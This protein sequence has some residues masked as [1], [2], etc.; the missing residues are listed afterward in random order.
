[1]KK[2]LKYIAFVLMGFLAG[3]SQQ[4]FPGCCSQDL[5]DPTREVPFLETFLFNFKTGS[6]PITTANPDG[7]LNVISQAV[8]LTLLSAAQEE[9][10]QG[11]GVISGTAISNGVPVKDVA[12]KITDVNGTL[13]AIRAEG[14]VIGSHLVL[15]DGSNCP[16][17]DAAVTVIENVCIKGDLFYNGLGGVPDFSNNR[18]T[19]KAG[20]FTVFNLPPGDV[21]LWTFRGGRGNARI[22]V[23]EDKISVG[24]VQVVPIPISTVLVEGVATEAKNESTLIAGA[25][26][27]ILGTQDSDLK[28]ITNSIGQY[29]LNPVG[30]N[31]KHL[32]KAEMSGHWTTYLTLN[33]VSIQTNI[34]VPG[35]TRNVVLYEN[36]YVNE[37][38]APMGS[39]VNTNLGIVTGLVQFGT[40][41][42]QHCAKFTVSDAAGI[43]LLSSGAV[44]VYRPPKPGS[45]GVDTLRAA[46]KN[47]SDPAQTG[48]DGFYFIYNLPP[49]EIFLNYRA[50]VSTG[51]PGN[52]DVSTG[53]VITTAF[54]G[55]VFVQALFNSGSGVSQ[56]LS[57]LIT[58]EAVVPA[59]N[60]QITVLG[61]V[62]RTYTICINDCNPDPSD[63]SPPP[64]DLLDVLLS[65]RAESDASGTYTIEKSANNND[66]DYPLVGGTAY[67]L[68]TSKVGVP[69]TYQDVRMTKTATKLDLLSALSVVPGA[70]QGKIYGNLINSATGRLA[71]DVRLIIT[72]LSGNLLQEITSSDGVFQTVDLPPGLVNLAIVSG[73]DSGNTV[74]RVYANG[75]TFV[76]WVMSKTI[77]AEVSA[78]GG[79]RDLDNTLV[80][81]ATLSVQGRLPGQADSLIVDGSG[82]Y[83]GELES[84]GRFVVKTEKSDFYDTHNFFPRSGLVDSLASQDLYAISRAQIATLAASAGVTLDST[85]GVLV[86]KTVEN[87]FNAQV[88]A[89]ACSGGG[90]YKSALGFFNQDAVLDI[91]IINCTSTSSLTVFFGNT[92]G[93]GT[94]VVDQSYPL[95]TK[96]SDIATGDF[97]GNGIADLVIA[98]EAFTDGDGDVLSFS[99]LLG[100]KKGGFTEL[101]PEATPP[102]P[103]IPL[104][105]QDGNK[106]NAN[107]TRNDPNAVVVGLF[108]SDIFPDLAVAYED[109]NSVIVYSGLGDGTFIPK[110]TS[111]GSIDATGVGTNPTDIAVGDFNKDNRLDLA[112]TNQGDGTVSVL[113][114]NTEGG[115]PDKNTPAVGTGPESILTVDINADGQLDLAVVNRG[116]GTITILTSD[117]A[118]TFTRLRDDDDVVVPD[119]SV[120]GDPSAL[121]W[122]D[123][124]GDNRVDLALADKSGNRVLTLFGDGDGRFSKSSTESLTITSPDEILVLDSN[125][126][127]LFDLIV[128]GSDLETLLGTEEP[129]G[130]IS[131]EARDLDGN[132]G[133][134]IVYPNSGSASTSSDGTF[135]IFNVPQ[136]LTLV[137]ATSGGSGNSLISAFADTV[138][139]TQIKTVTV[140]PFSV[141]VDGRAFDPVGPAPGVFV[142][143]VNVEVLGMGQKQTTDSQGSYNFT[144]D[145]N[146]EFVLKLLFDGP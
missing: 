27:S 12:L 93:D 109:D 15:P 113:L 104:T 126:D 119:I 16:T 46:C 33:T 29:T 114:G 127:G 94:F 107:N 143:N 5:D 135:V 132:V 133:G 85:K 6:G 117:I 58:N 62:D 8:L 82:N 10:A 13:L 17:N 138:S 71:T 3:C 68:K 144:L 72:D 92:N 139:F 95:G 145:A 81:Q 129:V 20:S 99:I 141:S 24:K 140:A 22:R 49:G 75:V 125:L 50:E 53:G 2:I 121:T 130:G 23:F 106:P 60:T 118:G 69:D 105:D 90:P 86:G 142:G 78:F 55:V 48:T 74:R 123:F 57:G 18:G 31:G 42:T 35:M 124:N 111:N 134:S 115:F 84:N 51:S 52:E 28:S 116:A 83:R 41:T 96:L 40:G 87:S 120:S 67:R 45:N 112:V 91:A 39:P 122:G 38:A 43:D 19:S 136:D 73:D 101:D 70:G 131:V 25:T 66:L 128:V 97:D 108:D 102:N 89:T 77:P 11:T 47:P 26:I 63:P 76:E 64:P 146:S 79:V 137:R 44:A 59:G 34:E 1:M 103:P 88:T 21:Y 54:P 9:I 7:N 37:L 14:R 56:D 110:R 65:T 61:I 4:D 32:I 36:S 98:N 100:D 80:P 30:T